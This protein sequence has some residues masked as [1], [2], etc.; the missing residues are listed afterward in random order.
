MTEMNVEESLRDPRAEKWQNWHDQRNSELAEEFGWLTLISYEW[1]DWVP[2][3]IRD[4]PGMFQVMSGEQGDFLRATFTEKDSVFRDGVPVVGEV[5]FVLENEG[6]DMSLH[7]TLWRAEIIRRSNRYAIRVRRADS[8]VRT[9]FEGVP[10]WGYTT[11]EIYPA[12]I[13]LLDEPIRGERSTARKDVHSS[14]EV[15][16]D[17]GV[18]IDGEEHHFQLE[19]TPE[20]GFHLTFHDPTN[21]EESAD[22]RFV[23]V[24]SPWVAGKKPLSE[25]SAQ[26]EVD[27]NYSMNF[28]AAFTPW[29][30][31][32]MPLAGNEW[33]TPVRAGERRVEQMTW[34][35]MQ[36]HSKRHKN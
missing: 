17:L 35:R 6:S 10:T 9:R 12:I 26:V 36:D 5:D 31:C 23:P 25:R 19:G 34:R 18:T 4:F 8:P 24:E 30:T 20:G 29:G 14:Y 27:F 3:P 21:G 7:T 1:I 22:W 11:R 2:T 15:T 32:P 28:P 13:T 33:P 16:A